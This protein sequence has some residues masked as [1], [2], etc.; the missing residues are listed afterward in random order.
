MVLKLNGFGTSSNW[1]KVFKNGP[2]EICGRQPLKNFTR[3]ILE[4]F[5]TIDIDGDSCHRILNTCV[6]FTKIFNTTAKVF[7]NTLSSPEIHE[8]CCKIF[9]C[10][11]VIYPRTEM[12][13]ATWWLSVYDITLNAI[14]IFDVFVMFYFSLFSKPNRK[15]YK[16]M[17]NTIYS[18]REND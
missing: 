12:L 4:Y 7:I 10:L 11:N 9:E 18:L 6:K 5:V 16:S 1:H 17:I 3:S 13:V 2:R 15:L 8:L 14:Y